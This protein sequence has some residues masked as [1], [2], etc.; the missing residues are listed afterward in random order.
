MKVT[1]RDH[2]SVTSHRL[3]I[4]SLWFVI[5]ATPKAASEELEC[6]AETCTEKCKK[7]V[8]TSVQ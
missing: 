3:P 1:G 7:E 8:A 2:R 4:Q 5:A 6:Y